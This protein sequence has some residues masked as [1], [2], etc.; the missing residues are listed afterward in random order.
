M[1]APVE[2]ATTGDEAPP[3]T[4]AE[5]RAE[6]WL[7]AL[8]VLAALTGVK[9]LGAVIPLVRTWGF[10][11]AL[12]LQL[13]VPLVLRDR[14]GVSTESLGLSLGRWRDDLRYFSIWAVV[15]TVPYALGYHLLQ[16]Y[17]GRP[18]T[19]SLTTGP[20]TTFVSQTLVIALAEELYFRGYLQERLQRLF[21]A[22]RTVFGAPFGVAIVLT[23]VI[24]A[25]A[26]FLGEYR[27]YRLGPFFPSLLFGWFRART[28]TIVAAVGF[29]AYAN[30]LSDVLRDLYS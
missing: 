20:F 18:F 21:P 3:P 17:V 8:G 13:Y 16:V 4:R 25:L 24:F 28:G 23:S 2:A 12:G 14:R 26:H 11:A 9:H 1:S 5:V 27:L 6:A 22:R 30:L 10:T 19:G 29:H 7:A 15:I